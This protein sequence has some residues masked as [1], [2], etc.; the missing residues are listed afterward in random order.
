[1]LN[2][3]KGKVPRVSQTRKPTQNSKTHIK[4]KLGGDFLIW[5]DQV[6]KEN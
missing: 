2:A 1:M 6:S 3:I 4:K 5:K